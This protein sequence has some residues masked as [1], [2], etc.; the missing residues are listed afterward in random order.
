MSESQRRDQDE[1]AATHSY[2]LD[3]TEFRVHVMLDDSTPFCFP[4]FVSA[5]TWPNAPNL[6]RID[7]PLAR[8]YPRFRGSSFLGGTL[9][10]RRRPLP[11]LLA[12]RGESRGHNERSR[13]C[14]C[15]VVLA[16]EPTATALAAAI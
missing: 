1:Y 6:F 11:T 5:L 15:C 4:N 12:F 8:P 13:P 7:T 2:P 3:A 9:A 16:R 10:T 14:F